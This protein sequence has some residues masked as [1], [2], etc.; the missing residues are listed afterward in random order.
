MVTFQNGSA[1]LCPEKDAKNLSYCHN[2]HI[3]F[4]IGDVAETMNNIRWHTEVTFI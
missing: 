1:G 2:S 4:Q 3:N